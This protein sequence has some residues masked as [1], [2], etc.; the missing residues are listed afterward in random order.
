[1]AAE[2]AK[3]H[4]SQLQAQQSASRAQYQNV[5][6][7]NN[8][9]S[10][11]ASVFRTD[12]SHN[13]Q[14]PR[15]THQPSN[16]RQH[17]VGR[18]TCYR[19]GAETPHRDCPARN[20]TC[21]YCHKVGH[22]AK[23]C[24]AKRRRAQNQGAPQPSQSTNREHRRATPAAAH[25]II[26]PHLVSDDQIHGGKL[27]SL[28]F[29]T[30]SLGAPPPIQITVNIEGVPLLMEVDS[31]AGHTIIGSQVFQSK[32]S[33]LK[34][35][36]CAINL[37]TW[38]NEKLNVLGQTQVKAEFRGFVAELTLLVAAGPGPSL[39]GRSWFHAL[40]IGVDGVH[41]CSSS[42]PL[43]PEIL[44][45]SHVFAPGLGKYSG[46]P[47]HIHL[48]DGASPVFRKARPVPYALLN[49]VSSEIDRLV[50]EG[51]LV[52]VKV[53]EWA[54]P[55]VN[56]E[57]R[58]GTIRMCGD[59]SSTV[60]PNCLRDVYPLPTI[61]E[62]LGKLAGGKYFARLDMSLAFLQLPVDAETAK[63][64]TLN[65]HKG[66][67]QVTRLSQGL[68]AAPGIFQRTME[69]LLV[70]LEGT[71]VYLDDIL[72]QAPTK[73][74]LWQRVRAVLR[75]LSDA[76]LHLRLDKCLFAVPKIEFVGY[77]LSAEGIHP[78]DKKVSAIL[79]APKPENVDSLRVYLGLVNYYDRFF[80]N[81]ASQFHVLYDLLK[82]GAKWEWGS[83]HEKCLSYVKDVVTKA[84][85]IHFNPDLPIVLAGD[86]SPHGIGAVISHVMPDG[87]E[88]PIAFGSRTLKPAER[89]YSQVD[90]EALAIIFGVTKF[91]MY[92]WGR[93]FTVY[94]DSKPVVGIFN[95]QRKQLPDIMSP[96][97]LRWCLF[98]ANFD[99]N[100][101]YRPGSH[102][103][104]A[105]FLS[106]LPLEEEGEDL[107]PDPAGVLFLEESAAQHSPLSAG[108]I[109]EAT[110]KDPVVSK[111]LCGVLHG[112]DFSENSPEVQRYLRGPPGSL[113]MMKGCLLRGNR[114]IIP[115]IYRSQ[116]LAMLH[117]VHQGIV[118]TKG[119]AR[120]YVWWPG[121]DEDIESLIKSCPQCSSVQNNPP[122]VPTIPWS[123]PTKPWSRV[124]VD[125]AG[126]IVGHTFLILV[127]AM[128]KWV[129]VASTR[130]SLSSKTTIANLR[131]WF[132]T[133]GLPDEI[134]TDNGPAFRSEEMS[135][136]VHKNGISHYKTPPYN[137][138][139][140]GLAERMVQTVKRLLLKLPANEWEKELANILLTLRT[141][142]NSTG[143]APSELLM[144]RRLKTVLDN[145]H[146]AHVNLNEQKRNSILLG[147][148]DASAN[149][150][151][152]GDTVFYRNYGRGGPWLKGVISEVE[153]PHNF[154]IIS[155][156]GHVERRNVNQLRR[157]WIGNKNPN[158]I[159]N[160]NPCSDF[161]KVQAA[162][163]DY[164]HSP[165][166][167]TWLGW[168]DEWV[169]IQN[170]PPEGSPPCDNPG[171]RPAT[172]PNSSRPRRTVKPPSHLDDFVLT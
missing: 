160:T 29:F 146:P 97:V 6:V 157:R 83:E 13:P 129:E 117:Q 81:K 76:G 110:R 124:H 37:T 153:G 165:E 93:R 23:M 108:A 143:S 16:R 63:V 125:F 152:V 164:P 91:Y 60:N 154:K 139:S 24:F 51:I 58:D 172:E 53:S 87:T 43:P 149:Y 73:S 26:E 15:S 99:C 162:T 1:M 169:A 65:T 40:N 136:F 48:K 161:P 127:D 14:A 118:R 32:F 86:A 8:R 45:F 104:N 72:I 126:P 9:D 78:T 71:L 84:A 137:P 158:I 121:I 115:P 120:S 92:L 77:Q 30:P 171:A 102:N 156:S 105:D 151:T 168:P 27:N 101:L 74:G 119:L 5:L 170:P 46:P 3:V 112:W 28:L 70:G 21:H 167:T 89:N 35:K 82:Q 113:S 95:P 163:E 98:L 36:P 123:I 109:A 39:L 7:V 140:N 44:D 106:R 103:G 79:S 55:T 107:S 114:V 96:R 22:L 80:P 68:S 52:P 148:R 111:V 135:D 31:G 147:R 90:K 141:T 25:A 62:V 42:V 144:G 85:L 88:R 142:P 61:D 59:Y 54:T 128:S 17:E 41:L 116:V 2:Q 122:K 132:A 131:S 18:T 66:L 138:A 67:F 130:G 33:S 75:K 64:L 69:S 10:P 100:V 12:R 155:N 56:V 4:V 133:H 49:R 38:S 159:V 34:L 134:V 19:C 11:D 57:K 145:L 47:T 20:A 150:F 50:H 94:S 166:N